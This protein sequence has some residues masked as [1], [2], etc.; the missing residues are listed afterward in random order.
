[1]TDILIRNLSDDVILKIDS[2]AKT[3]KLSR[4]VYVKKILER[5]A[6]SSE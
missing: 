4:N 6:L 3:A 1:M 5:H 2:M